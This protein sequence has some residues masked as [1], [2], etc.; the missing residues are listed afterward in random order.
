MRFDKDNYLF[1]LDG[2]IDKG[3]LNFLV[4]PRDKLVGT[5]L[6]KLKDKKV[7]GSTSVN[8]LSMG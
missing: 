6:L 3:E 5:S 4:H 7:K 8:C 2:D 1:A